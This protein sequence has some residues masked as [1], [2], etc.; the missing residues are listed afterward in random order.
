MTKIQPPLRRKYAPRASKFLC[1][2]CK[3]VPSKA[4]EQASRTFDRIVRLQDERD[5]LTDALGKVLDEN[6]LLKAK[7]EQVGRMDRIA[8]FAPADGIR[9]ASASTALSQPP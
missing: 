1:D 9:L 3:P 6:R 8:G 2:I 5:A 7:L 4:T